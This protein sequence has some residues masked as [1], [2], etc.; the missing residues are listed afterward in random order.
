MRVVSVLILVVI[1][2]MSIPAG[3]QNVG[4]LGDSIVNYVDINGNKQG[5]WKKKYPN[6]SIAYEGYFFN[7][8]PVGVFKRYHENGK[9]NTILNCLKDTFKCKAELFYA[10]QKLAAE[11]NYYE[12]KK[13]S[14]WKYYAEDKSLIS[15]EG[16][17]H[18]QKHGEFRTFFPG[19]M[20]VAEVQNYQD[21]IAHGIWRKYYLS[22]KVRMETKI[23]EG[24]RNGPFY[25][26]YES[27][28][29]K[30]QGSYVN[31]MRDKTWIFYL[32]DR[33]GAE[34]VKVNYTKG[35]PENKEELEK[36]EQKEFKKYQEDRYK[37]EEP[38][39]T[40]RKLIRGS[41]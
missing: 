14:I 38:E 25:V 24:K 31:D 33:S 27:G 5:P 6:G 10:T 36:L 21:G 20:Q 8:K 1:L 22:G 7:N 37:L 23:S 11:G 26:Y 28:R 40:Y 4:Q 34:T 19:G 41:Y 12:Q 18:G 35:V 17:K 30:V 3:A 2:S 32:K 16:F 29:V 15:I 9:L 39:E 13:D